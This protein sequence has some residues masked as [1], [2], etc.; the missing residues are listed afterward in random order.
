[1]LPR[2]T[3]LLLL[4][5]LILGCGGK[6]GDAEYTSLHELM[7]EMDEAHQE[8]ASQEMGDALD[9]AKEISVLARYMEAPGVMIEEDDYRQ[10]LAGLQE[11]NAALIKA[12]EEKDHKAIPEAFAAQIQ[13][14][15]DCHR[16]YR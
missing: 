4:S 15:K 10:F 16:V 3:T 14:C 9:G 7:E 12:L 5:I 1:M 13:S 6:H 11:A 2:A 8:S